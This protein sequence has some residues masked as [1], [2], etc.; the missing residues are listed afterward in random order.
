[1]TV[2]KEGNPQV[3][4][5]SSGDEEKKLYEVGFKRLFGLNRPEIPHIFI[6]CFAAACNGL[7]N[8]V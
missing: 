1:M 8:P 7:L 2:D 6:A 5:S 4:A 3:V